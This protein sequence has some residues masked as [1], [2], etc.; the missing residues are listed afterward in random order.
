[1]LKIADHVLVKQQKIHPLAYELLNRQRGCHDLKGNMD[2]RMIHTEIKQRT[3]TNG[4]KNN[5]PAQDIELNRARGN[6]CD[7]VV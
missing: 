7:H 5:R 1:M 6:R 4:I 3:M 2:L